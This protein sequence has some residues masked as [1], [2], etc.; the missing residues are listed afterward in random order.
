[1][2]K[3]PIAIVPYQNQKH[4]QLVSIWLRAVQ[5]T[6]Y[7]LTQ[8]DIAFYHQMVRQQALTSVDLWMALNEADQPLGFIGL[9]ESHVSMLFVD[10]LWHG[11]GIGSRLLAHATHLN[12]GRLTVDVNEQN[13]Q[14][15]GFYQ[16]YGFEQVGRS[17]LDLSGRPFPLLHFQLNIM[18]NSNH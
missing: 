11:Y 2:F 17:E 9:E 15:V 18:P 10:P 6:H 4:D 5:Q 7:F 16:R 1:M 12:A 3:L 8:E 13:S 14:A